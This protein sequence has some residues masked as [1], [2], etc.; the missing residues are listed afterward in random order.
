MAD[1]NVAQEAIK[2]GFNALVA[3]GTLGFGWIVGKRLSSRWALRQKRREQDL[4]SASELHGLYGEFFAV[5]KLWNYACSGAGKGLA[6][7][8]T[9]SLIQRAAL[10][11]AGFEA[12]LVRL[13]SERVLGTDVRKDLGMLRQAF[14]CLRESIAASTPLPWSHS[15]HPQYV[16]FKRLACLSSNLVASDHGW[17]LPTCDEAAAALREITSN[18][19]E[20]AWDALAE[21]AM[22]RRHGL[23]KV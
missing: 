9:W 4:A 10:V 12:L 8:V 11:D 22:S 6:S 17:Q 20:L 14:Q 7:D 2:A 23:S 19:H 15:G 1:W 21:A 3:A 18:Q 16:E 13:T 5:W